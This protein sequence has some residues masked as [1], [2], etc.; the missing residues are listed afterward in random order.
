MTTMLEKM[1]RAV[2]DR[3]ETE[4]LPRLRMSWEEGTAM[5]KRRL[6]EDCRA[7]LLAIRE[8]DWSVQAAGIRDAGNPKT[9]WVAMIDAILNEKPEGGA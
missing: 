7:A 1:A 2:W 3:R 6:L 8:P 4:N 9:G 5:A